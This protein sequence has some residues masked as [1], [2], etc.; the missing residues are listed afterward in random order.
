MSL[1][2]EIVPITKTVDDHIDAFDSIGVVQ[3]KE[4]N[5]RS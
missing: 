2:T 1:L 3:L 4:H 5:G